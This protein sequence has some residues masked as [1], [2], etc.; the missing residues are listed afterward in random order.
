MHRLANPDYVIHL[1]RFNSPSD[2]LNYCSLMNIKDYA[3]EFVFVCPFT[4]ERITMKIGRSV[5]GKSLGERVYRQS[6]HIPGWGRKQLTGSSGSDMLI[7]LADMKEKYSHKAADLTTDNISINIWNV[8]YETNP[9]LCDD[10]YCTRLCENVLLDEYEEIHGEFPIGNKKDTRNEMMAPH[11]ERELFG[12]LF[13]E[14]GSK[15]KLDNLVI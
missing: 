11:V 6:G 10:A 13:D 14:V 5:S 2:I 7:V 8:T 4:G 15:E 12:S 3:Y 1:R 9:H